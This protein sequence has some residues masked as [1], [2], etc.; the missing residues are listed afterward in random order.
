MISELITSAVI[1]ITIYGIMRY[2]FNYKIIRVVILGADEG[3]RRSVTDR[4]LEGGVAFGNWPEIMAGATRHK[5]DIGHSEYTFLELRGDPVEYYHLYDHFDVAIFIIDSSAEDQKA[6]L[7]LFERAMKLGTLK[8]I[9]FMVY[10]I[11]K[12][13]EAEKNLSEDEVKEVYGLE[14][15]SQK[16]HIQPVDFQLI[17][18]GAGMKW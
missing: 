17:G 10:A 15:F 6:S 9:K 18:I 4:I 7:D 2:Y 5:V 8:D 16:V 12:D 13:S 14:R 3:L 1:S 11:K